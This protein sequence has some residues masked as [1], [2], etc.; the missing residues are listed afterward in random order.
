MTETITTIER[1]LSFVEHP[2]NDYLLKYGFEQ[3]YEPRSYDRE[4]YGSRQMAKECFRNAL[5]MAQERSLDYVEGYALG[6][7][8][9]VHHAWCLDAD[10]KVVDPTWRDS[11]DTDCGLCEGGEIE[12]ESEWD[13]DGDVVDYERVTCTFCGGSGE[14]EHRDDE[15][16][17][18][19]VVL[20]TAISLKL[21]LMEGTWGVLD[22][23]GPD[24][25]A[26][27]PG[28]LDRE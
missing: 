2:V 10:G 3:P 22:K 5:M 17:Y 20:P 24:L 18:F 12:V 4:L 25:L 11:T 14:G 26:I 6:H 1:Y 27:A 9:P 21:V 28:D 15:R 8:I 19:G 13:D 16:T 7:G 23:L